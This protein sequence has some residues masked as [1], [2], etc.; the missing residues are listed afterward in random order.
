M[1]DDAIRV[2]EEFVCEISIE[3][4]QG[5]IAF[6][7]IDGEEWG[8]ALIRKLTNR[9][10]QKKDETSIILYNAGERLAEFHCGYCGEKQQIPFYPTSQ[11][12][13]RFRLFPL[14]ERSDP[15]QE[16][17]CSSDHEGRQLER[18]ARA[19]KVLENKPRGAGDKEEKTECSDQ[20]IH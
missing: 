20:S 6:E 16:K 9:A 10:S 11:S 13:S 2:I 5:D 8:E 19:S 18:L 12:L 3:L 15:Y 1:I 14:D 7:I 17:P 4:G